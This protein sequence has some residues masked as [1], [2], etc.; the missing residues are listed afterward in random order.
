MLI[1]NRVT[2][3]DTIDVLKSQKSFYGDFT[4]QYDQATIDLLKRN[5]TGPDS[6][7]VVAMQDDDF[8][9]FISCDTEWWEDNSFF[10]REIFVSPD[11]QKKGIG[12]QLMRKV[13][14][15]AHN[16]GASQVVTQTAFENVP[17]QKLCQSLGFKTWDN[18]QWKQGITYK[19]SLI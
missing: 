10:L 5:F 15:H 4:Y 12:E 16:H 18:P 17:M 13:L 9:G 6:L 8:A 1:F 3:I 2:D 11:H 7:Y 19:F 14:E